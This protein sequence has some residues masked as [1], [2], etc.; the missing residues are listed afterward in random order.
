VPLDD[1]VVDAGRHAV[2][3]FELFASR[4]HE[5]TKHDTTHH[6]ICIT[7]TTTTTI[8]IIIIS[9]PA[10]AIQRGCVNCSMYVRIC[11]SVYLF[12]CLCLSGL[13][14][15]I[16]RKHIKMVS[17]DGLLALLAEHQFI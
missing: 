14:Q 5:R 15:L 12:V 1:L 11:L 17:I 6:A 10:A 3:V 4:E 7:T 16:I 8:I 13:I 2:P 9:H